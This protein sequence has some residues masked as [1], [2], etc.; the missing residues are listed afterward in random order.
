ML[1][2]RPT[3]GKRSSQAQPFD[4]PPGK[5]P[6]EE[7]TSP[8]YLCEVV[9]ATK[10]LAFGLGSGF[11]TGYAV[12]IVGMSMLPGFNPGGAK[13][14]LSA[15]LI[16][17]ALWVSVMLLVRLIPLADRRLRAAWWSATGQRKKL[18]RFGVLG[19]HVASALVVWRLALAGL[20]ALS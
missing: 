8:R 5:N 18:M 11:L 17:M 9:T 20:G 14:L 7:G 1:Q 4:A 10:R 2:R 12:V 19:L 6:R 13:V 3:A 16:A 15:A